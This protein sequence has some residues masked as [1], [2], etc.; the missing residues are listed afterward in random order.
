MLATIPWYGWIWIL[1]FALISLFRYSIGRLSVLYRSIHPNFRDGFYIFRRRIYYLICTL[2][3]LSYWI[4]EIDIFKGSFTLWGFRWYTLLYL[5]ML[6]A[7]IFDE[8][9]SCFG[10][11]GYI[12]DFSLANI[13]RILSLGSMVVFVIAY[14]H[15]AFAK[16]MGLCIAVLFM[17][18]IIFEGYFLVHQAHYK[19]NLAELEMDNPTYRLDGIMRELI[20]NQSAKYPA[21]FIGLMLILHVLEYPNW[22]IIDYLSIKYPLPHNFGSVRWWVWLY[23]AGIIFYLGHPVGL[24]I[25]NLG[26][27]LQLAR[28]CSRLLL[29]VFA[30]NF[31]SNLNICPSKILVGLLLCI[32]IAFEVYLRFIDYSNQTKTDKSAYPIVY[33]LWELLLIAPGIIA[34]TFLI[35]F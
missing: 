26:A 17:Y 23:S 28:I 27:G 9:S 31:W 33:Q 34:G 5:G 30:V 10:W 15:P 2:L 3:I 11:F 7:S 13:F 21:M 18:C 1:S 6:F 35:I 14:Y 22:N 20:T 24:A 29:I 4:P 19:A 8:I 32:V 12:G 16:W 25:N